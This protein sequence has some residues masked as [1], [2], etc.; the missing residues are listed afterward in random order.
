MGADHASRRTVPALVL[1]ALAA[2]GLEALRRQT[3]SELPTSGRPAGG[4][5][6]GALGSTRPPR[7]AAGRR[8]KVEQLE[9]LA[10]LHSSGELNDEEYAAL[11]R[12]LVS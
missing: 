6:A 7:A 9:R 8:P 1:I 10:A 12:D 4:G 2:L 3:L 5:T 11:K